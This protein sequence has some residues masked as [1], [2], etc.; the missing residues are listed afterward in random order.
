MLQHGSFAGIPVP[1]A[2]ARTPLS[3]D[4]VL[5]QFPFAQPRLK[6]GLEPGS[7]SPEFPS[8]RPQRELRF[9]AISYCRN[10]RLHMIGQKR[11]W[12]FLSSRR[13]GSWFTARCNGGEISRGRERAHGTSKERALRHGKFPQARRPGKDCA[14]Q[15]I[16][17]PCRMSERCQLISLQRL[18]HAIEKVRWCRDDG[19]FST[20]PSCHLDATGRGLRHSAIDGEISRG[21]ERA[22]GTSKERALWHGKFPQARRPGKDCAIQGISYPCHMSERCRLRSLQRLL[23]AIEKVRWCRDDGALAP[24]HRE[25]AVVSR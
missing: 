9:Q 1:P 5:P 24:C 4:L 17:Y 25:G 20:S 8:P 14:I 3:G 22:H 13:H 21:R 23:H 15:G 7:G 18:L 11:F 16:S 6:T 12:L 19:V 10:S 2:S